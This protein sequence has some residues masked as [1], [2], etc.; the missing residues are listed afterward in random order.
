MIFTFGHE[1]SSV[2]VV[3][4]T[5]SRNQFQKMWYAMVGQL[6]FLGVT[7]RVPNFSKKMAQKFSSFLKQGAKTKWKETKKEKGK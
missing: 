2:I 4:R 1:T 7:K 5:G 6:I 3:N